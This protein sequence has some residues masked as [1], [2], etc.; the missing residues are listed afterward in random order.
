MK[1]ELNENVCKARDGTVHFK[2]DVV[3]NRETAS[4]CIKSVEKVLGYFY[5]DFAE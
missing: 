1:A 3:L 5:D 4:K 2:G